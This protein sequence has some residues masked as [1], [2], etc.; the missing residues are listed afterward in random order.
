MSQIKGTTGHKHHI[1]G[2]VY[3]KN[4][5]FSLIHLKSIDKDNQNQTSSDREQK[6]LNSY[7]LNSGA[8]NQNSFINKPQTIKSFQNA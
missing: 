5:C 7:P 2:Y 4:V 3:F 6:R 8:S 1:A